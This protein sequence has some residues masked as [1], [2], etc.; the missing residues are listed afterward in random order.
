VNRI[1]SE[2]SMGHTSMLP[3]QLLRLDLSMKGNRI[4]LKMS[5]QL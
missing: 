4:P 5:W 2:Q 3:Y 1:V